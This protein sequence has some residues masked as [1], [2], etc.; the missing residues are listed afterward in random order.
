MKCNN[1]ISCKGND[2]DSHFKGMFP[3]FHY[4]FDFLGEL[5]K[6]NEF[7]ESL[8]RDVH[9]VCATQKT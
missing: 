8:A 3:V 9:F 1:E 2:N 5:D 4:G 6:L 7:Q